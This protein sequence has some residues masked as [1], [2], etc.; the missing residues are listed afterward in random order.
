VGILPEE[1]SGEFISRAYL[2]NPIVDVTAAMRRAK[3]EPGEPFVVYALPRFAGP[4]G[5]GVQLSGMVT[6]PDGSTVAINLTDDGRANDSGDDVAD[7]GIYSATLTDTSMTGAYSFHIMAMAVDAKQVGHT[8]GPEEEPVQVS[9]FV[10]EVRLSATVNDLPKIGSQ[11]CI[12]SGASEPGTQVTVPI[13]L[14]NGNGIAGFQVDV[15]YNPAVLTPAAVRLG[16]D[17]PAASGWSVASAAV[18]VGAL[19]VLGHSNPP[20]PL[21]PGFREVALVDFDIAPGAPLGASPFFL[22]DCVLSDPL[23]RS[24]QCHLCQEPGEVVVRNASTFRFRPI[25]APV[26]VDRFDPLPFP[27]AVEALDSLGNVATGYGG[28]AG[29]SIP[30]PICAGT[31]MPASLGFS[32]GVGGPAPFKIACCLDPL[33]PATTTSLSLRASDPGIMVGGMSDP[34]QGVAKGDLNADNSVNVLDVTRDV[35][36]ALN[37]PVAVPPPTGFQAWAGNML[38]QNC[39]V[40]GRIDVLDVVRIRNKVLGRPPLCP[41]PTGRVA[42]SVA[43]SAVADAAAGPVSLS[44]VKAGPKEYLVMVRGARDLGG[45]QLELRGVGS[46]TT[47]SPGELIAGRGWQLTDTLEEGVLRVI[48]FSNG[49]AGVTGEGA[50]LRL[51]GTG[52]PKLRQ[53]I[54]SDSEGRALPLE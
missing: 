14:T 36:L 10:R 2:E 40:D 41:C 26:G 7:D 23:G 39:A 25:P 22:R 3:V 19:R 35:R 31:L 34:F 54:A 18:G 51:T 49:A 6:K 29:M 27:V 44:I 47:V 30:Q 46:K 48:V 50:V 12:G 13:F 28:T 43:P 11:I 21:G 52:S 9:N 32:G 42:G 24:I 20:A 38:D 4:I 16:A 53:V 15:L 45:L 17:T 1:G 8:R 5:I 33:L 37:L